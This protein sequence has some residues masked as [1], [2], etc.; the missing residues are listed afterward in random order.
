MNH[1]KPKHCQRQ[2]QE[3]NQIEFSPSSDADDI[4]ETEFFPLSTSEGIGEIEVFLSP[5]SE[6]EREFASSFNSKGSRENDCNAPKAA[7][8]T[9]F[10][11]GL[12]LT[13]LLAGFCNFF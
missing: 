8:W 2:N 6:G 11:F 9:A 5:D 1:E 12:S 7:A 4:E 3:I 10:L 13:D